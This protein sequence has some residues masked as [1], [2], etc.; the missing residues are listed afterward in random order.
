MPK[1]CEVDKCDC[2]APCTVD[3]CVYESDD[4]DTERE[5]TVEEIDSV[6]KYIVELVDK[7]KIP[8]SDGERML[9]TLDRVS[10]MINRANESDEEESDDEEQEYREP[11]EFVPFTHKGKQYYKGDNGAC[12]WVFDDDLNEIGIY[13]T[14]DDIELYED[15]EDA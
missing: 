12:I 3:Y 7:E 5:P 4:D 2:E 8:E 14:D 1:P 15:Y 11:T 6:Y 13:N 9:H 10:N